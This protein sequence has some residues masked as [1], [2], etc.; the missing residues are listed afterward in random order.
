MKACGIRLRRLSL[1]F[2]SA[3][4][5]E[6]ITAKLVWSEVPQ[7]L[8]IDVLREA[9]VGDADP[10]VPTSKVEHHGVVVRHRHDEDFSVVDQVDHQFGLPNYFPIFASAGLHGVSRVDA[11]GHEAEGSEMVVAAGDLCD[12][13]ERRRFPP[14]PVHA[15][16]LSVE[17]HEALVPC[18]SFL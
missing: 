11:H 14:R 1:R 18:L 10:R 13:H 15:D 3:I 2:E 7:V 4:W 5:R 12:V 17:D 9:V 8:L 16:V 6:R